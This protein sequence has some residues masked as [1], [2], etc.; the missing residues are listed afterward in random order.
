MQK[1]GKRRSPDELTQVSDSGD[2]SAGSRFERCLQRLFRAR[3]TT[4]RVFERSQHTCSLKY[5]GD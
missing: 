3:P 5:D 1:G 2:K 4:G